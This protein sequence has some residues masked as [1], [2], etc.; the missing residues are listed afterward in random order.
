[1]QWE[2][3]TDGRVNMDGPM[4]AKIFQAQVQLMKDSLD[5]G[6]M[7]FQGDRENR[8]YKQFK[9]ETMRM[10]HAFIDGFW[11]ALLEANLVEACECGAVPRRWSD[12]PYC[13][14]SG[15]VAKEDLSGPTEDAG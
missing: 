13:G 15:F 1:M 3:W 4:T 6:L 5:R 2:K 10:Y 7:M 9:Q 11:A 14:G 12:C 8:G